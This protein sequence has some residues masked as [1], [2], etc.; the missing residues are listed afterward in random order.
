MYAIFYAEGESFLTDIGGELFTVRL[1]NVATLKIYLTFVNSNIICLLASATR[2]VF[3]V[4]NETSH[5]QQ[6]K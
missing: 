1:N 6:E 2:V 5:Q 4:A 3:N